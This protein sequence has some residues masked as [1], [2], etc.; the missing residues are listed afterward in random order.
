[1]CLRARRTARATA[2]CHGC[3]CSVNPKC[4]SEGSEPQGGPGRRERVGFRKHAV[5]VE[6]ELE[7]DVRL[8]ED[9]DPHGAGGAL[10]EHDAVARVLEGLT[11]LA[12]VALER[13]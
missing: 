9:D 11:R 6:I 12:L 10:Y 13:L 4:R 8:V 2:S 3:G 7:V 5:A 1:M